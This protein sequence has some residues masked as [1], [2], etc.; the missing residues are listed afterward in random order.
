[1]NP[2][3]FGHRGVPSL[4][5]EN[6]LKS[7]ELI[8]ANK[9][10]GVEL[11]VH[12]SSDNRLVVIHDFNTLKLTGEDYE[13]S[14]TTYSILKDLD[15]GEGEKIPLLSEVFKTLGK[16]VI[17]DIEIKSRGKN[18]KQLAEKLL[19]I[20]QE[21]KLNDYCIVTSFDPFIIK[22]FNRLKSG[23]PTGI[24]YS[25]DKSVPLL[26]RHGLGQL[27]TRCNIIKPNHTQL[28]GTL[29]FL[30]TKILKK[31][32]YTWTVNSIEDYEKSIK[33]GCTGICTNFPQNF[34]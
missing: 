4:A 30:Y 14:E 13:I 23:I 11:D 20:I 9:I 18:R 5:P 34:N 24:I 19:E 29:F 3:I 16:E 25:K 2:I 21:Y 10:E 26:L 32:C 28:K 17:Y 33:A 31:E 22:R 8:R 12:L 1:M 7:F 15:I 6:S 27:V